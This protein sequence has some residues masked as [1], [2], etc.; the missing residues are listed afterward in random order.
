MN[1]ESDDLTDIPMSILFLICIVV[2]SIIIA[3]TSANQITTTSQTETYINYKRCS[4]NKITGIIHDIFTNN[5]IQQNS[6]DNWELYYPCNYTNVESE[7][8]TIRMKNKVIYAV[9]GC[10]I[11]ASKNSIW[12]LLLDAYGRTE[13]KILMPN[14]FI[15]SNKAHLKEFLELYSPLN[16]YICKKNIQNKNGLL[17]TNNLDLLLQCHHRGYKILQEYYTNVFLLHGHKLNLR[18]YMFVFCDTDG[19]KKAY[20]HRNGKCMYTNKVYNPSSM[21]FEEQITSVNVKKEMYDTFPL[22]FVDLQTTLL[23][24]HGI[25]FIDDI[26]KPTCAK[27]TKI[28]YA[29][30]PALC[31]QAHLRTNVR[32]QLFGVD[33]ILTDKLEPYVLEFNKG[34]AMTPIN[35]KDYKLKRCVLEDMLRLANIIHPQM[36]TRPNGFAEIAYIPNKTF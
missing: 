19:T 35:K 12:Q 36:I 2:L 21:N 9:D 24:E 26:F 27:L 11:I 6:F 22:D 18:M 10:D 15:L 29:A 23:N 32:F 3:Y 28:M 7:L 17:L 25:K 4:K 16:L 34:P 8:R 31:S 33:I 13:S 14:T 1:P 30:L 20:I 5:G